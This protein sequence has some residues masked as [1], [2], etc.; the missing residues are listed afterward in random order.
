MLLYVHVHIWYSVAYCIPHFL[1]K[2]CLF[3]IMCT[4]SQPIYCSFVTRGSFTAQ[5]LGCVM[6]LQKEPDFL[7]EMFHCSAI[8]FL[9]AWPWELKLG[10]QCMYMCNGHGYFLLIFNTKLNLVLYYGLAVA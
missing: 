10:V 6:C 9:M 2:E 4:C 3:T 1:V 8:V 5:A 7:F